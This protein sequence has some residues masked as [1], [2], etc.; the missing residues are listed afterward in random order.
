M[1]KAIFSDGLNE[2]TAHGLTQWDKGQE[3]E[4]THPSLSGSFEVHFANKRSELA[5]VVV[6]T[7]SDGVAIVAIPNIVL[8]KPVDVIA[9]VYETNGDTTGETI[10]T[11]N[12]PIEKRPKPTDYVYTEDELKILEYETIMKRL[13]VV[14]EEYDS[15]QKELYGNREELF[16]T[17]TGEELS[18]DRMEGCLCFDMSTPLISGETYIVTVDGKEHTVIAENTWRDEENGYSAVRL[19]VDVIGIIWYGQSIV[20][21]FDTNTIYSPNEVEEPEEWRSFGEAHRGKRASPAR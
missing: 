3:L 19:K 15:I 1:I 17:A 8:T 13:D 21:S 16:Y 5:Y 9:W 7:E 18:W 11:I 14:Q 20:E 4:I 12:L 10:A 6:A 2:T